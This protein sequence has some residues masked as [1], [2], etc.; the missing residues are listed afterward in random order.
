MILFGRDRLAQFPDAWIQAGYFPLQ[1]KTQLAEHDPQSPRTADPLIERFE[2]WSRAHLKQRFSLQ[3]A[4]KA[5]ATSSRSLQRRCEAVLGKS[6]LAY[7]Q[8]LRVECAQALIRGSG[9][10]MALGT[11]DSRLRRRC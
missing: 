8:D 6:P 3:E 9:W 7:F 4:A 10:R 2:E 5:L 1:D 11:A